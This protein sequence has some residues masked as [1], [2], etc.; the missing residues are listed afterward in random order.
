MRLRDIFARNLRRLR[1]GKDL[2]Q[3]E[4]A[5]AAKISR[6]Y[7]SALERGAYSASIDVIEGLAE[8]LG[9]EP[10]DLLDKNLKAKR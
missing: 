4:V 10:K 1:D 8:A 2:S 3:E 9:V 7:L 6:E 5:H